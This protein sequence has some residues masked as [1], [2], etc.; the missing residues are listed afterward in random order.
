M[1]VIG[2]FAVVATVLATIIP[3]LALVW[4]L[5]QIRQSIGP[6]SESAAFRRVRLLKSIVWVSLVLI[7]FCIVEIALALTVHNVLPDLS[8]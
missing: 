3:V 6:E 2:Y 8:L 5:G 1:S 4:G 7:S